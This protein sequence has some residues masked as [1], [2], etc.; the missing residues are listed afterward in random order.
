MSV[1]VVVIILTTIASFLLYCLRVN[2]SIAILA[3]VN[4]TALMVESE[5]S[6][7][8]HFEGGCPREANTSHHNYLR[9]LKKCKCYYFLL[10]E[11]EGIYVWKPSIQA[12][13]LC[14]YFYGYTSTQVFGGR[15]AEKWGGKWV[16]GIGILG[17]AIATFL[18]PISADYIMFISALRVLIGAFHGLVYSS[19]YNLFMKWV[20]QKERSIAIAL[21][22]GAGPFGGFVV[23]PFTGFLCDNSFMGGWPAA[24][25][26]LAIIACVWSA[27]W[28]IFVTDLPENHPRISK[29]EL[30]LIKSG[31]NQQTKPEQQ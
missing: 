19:V 25:Y 23:A 30:I 18:V 7:S 26:L 17:S 27:F 29:A 2:L 14:S 16:C 5:Q 1:R 12:I 8:E 9:K 20:P 15:F 28:F 4:N 13:I 22:M 3:M 21:V 6:I 10:F 24:F 31:S 11:K